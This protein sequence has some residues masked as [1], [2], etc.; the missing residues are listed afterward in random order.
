MKK[1]MVCLMLCGLWAGGAWGVDISLKPMG[2]YATGVFNA[3]G[4][5]IV[6]YH[7]AFKWLFITNGADPAIDVVR[8]HPSGRPVFLFKIGV[9]GKP[10]SVAAHRHYRMI[11]VSVQGAA[12]TDPGTVEFYYV[13]GQH[14]GT[15]QVGSLPDMITWTPD[16]RKLLVANEGEPS[17]DYTIDPPGSVSI[18]TLGAGPWL[19]RMVAEATLETVGFDSVAVDPG[20]RIFGPGATAQNNLEPEYIAVSEDSTTAWVTLQENN[21]IAKLDIGTATFGWVRA[22]GFKDHGKLGSGLDASDK[23]KA[24]AITPW[25]VRGLYLPDAIAAF[26]LGDEQYL[27]T[28]NEGDIRA[29]AGYSEEARIGGLLLDPVAFAAWPDLIK[30]YNLG[31]LKVTN[32][33]GDTDGDG[34]YDELYSFGARSFTIWN[35][36]GAIVSDS[37][38]QF[39][40][41][42]AAKYPANFNASDDTALFD[43][44]SDDKGPEPEHVVVGRFGDS[45]VAFIGLERTG[46][47]L[48]YD[49]SDAAKPRFLDYYN[50]RDFLADPVTAEAGDLSTEGLLLIPANNSP[51]RTPLLVASNEISGT[52]TVFEVQV[53]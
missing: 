49:V 32:T 9:P 5:Q 15:V 8:I 19:S 50:N 24:I 46:G 14:L 13:T 45:T 42:T 48:A 51:T 38:D 7:P 36:E 2:T 53:R 22:L 20:V 41:I 33:M 34:D 3:A 28:G 12:V 6:D 29:Y 40:Q 30:S 26:T 27:I 11:A 35:S 37:G 18:I 1:S 23:D 52:T 4:A 31:R 21:A 39:E 47:I 10:L 43:S 16:G 17:A 25:P 44:R